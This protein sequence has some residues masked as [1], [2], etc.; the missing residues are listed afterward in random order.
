MNWKHH[1]RRWIVV[2]PRLLAMAMVF[3]WTLFMWLEGDASE[4]PMGPAPEEGAKAV[5]VD[6]Q[7]SLTSGVLVLDTG[8]AKAKPSGAR[9]GSTLRLIGTDGQQLCVLTDLNQNET[10]GGTHCIS[11]DHQRGRIYFLENADQRLTA[12][13]KMGKVLWRL[14]SVGVSSVAVDARS[15]NIWCEVGASLFEKK[16]I[17]VGLDGKILTEYPW[18]GV[19]IV[20]D[21]QSD[22]FWVAGR[23]ILRVSREGK[24]FLMRPLPELPGL[25]DVPTVI[26]ARN[27]AAVSITPDVV[28]TVGSAQY[29]GAWVAVRS[30]PDVKG[31][32]NRLI[33]LD[34]NGETRALVEL[35]EVDPFAVACDANGNCWVADRAKQLLQYDLDGNQVLQLPI[36]ALAIVADEV[37][38]EMCVS[39]EEGL[40]RINGDGRVTGQTKFSYPSKQTWL[41]VTRP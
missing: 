23:Q 9:S 1:L 33:R 4:L 34:D 35:A 32:R 5:P 20:Y 16:T 10:I 36:P 28:H 37:R 12:L 11:M 17:V 19:D 30:H 29:G 15:G 25:P 6:Q 26:N 14:K 41:G 38:G 13:D 40:L 24:V 3:V 31:S 39:T 7:Q 27:W 8:S 21:P 2:T 18:G 22:V